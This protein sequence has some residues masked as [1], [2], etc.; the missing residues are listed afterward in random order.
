VEGGRDEVDNIAY[1]L[2]FRSMSHWK[3]IPFLTCV[4]TQ[5]SFR[6][7]TRR[8][9]RVVTTRVYCVSTIKIIVKITY[10][11][12][13]CAW[14]RITNNEQIIRQHPVPKPQTIKNKINRT[15]CPGR[16]TIPS[17]RGRYFRTL[18]W[19]D[20]LHDQ[21]RYHDADTYLCLNMRLHEKIIIHMSQFIKIEIKCKFIFFI[22]Q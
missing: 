19:I 11:P 6:W 13:I 8:T 16:R 12:N 18:D 14:P 21:S 1:L 17:G 5:R 4:S 9:P 20:R 15:S 7:T 2:A 3:N 10:F 22:F